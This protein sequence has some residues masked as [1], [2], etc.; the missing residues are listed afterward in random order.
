MKWSSGSLLFLLE[1]GGTAKGSK[2]SSSSQTDS[3]GEGAFN[4]LSRL[5]PGLGADEELFMPQM[6]FVGA[7]GG[8]GGGGDEGTF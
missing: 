3:G 4:I 8:G 5:M 6:V 2:S 1:M 7:G